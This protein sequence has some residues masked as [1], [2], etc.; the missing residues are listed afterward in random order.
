MGGADAAVAASIVDVSLL[1]QIIS[2]LLVTMDYLCIVLAVLNG[3]NVT[4]GNQLLK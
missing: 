1:S 2:C 4:T 3:F